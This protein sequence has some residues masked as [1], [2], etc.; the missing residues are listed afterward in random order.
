[1]GEPLGGK[2]GPETV[3]VARNGCEAG[4]TVVA[5]KI[6]DFTTLDICRAVIASAGSCIKS[7]KSRARPG[8][9]HARWRILGA[10]ALVGCSHGFAP[11]L[12]GCFRLLKTI[13]EP[14]FLLLPKNRGWW[15]IFAKIRNLG[16]AVL[17]RLRRMT[18]VIG[19]AG[20]EYIEHF[21]GK[22]S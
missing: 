20:V 4:N 15:F 2:S 17:D 9:G 14:C 16:T 7:R 1:W 11:A 6:V 8:R 21:L 3:A 22:E 13:Q 5:N 19:A 12:P 10:T 18:V